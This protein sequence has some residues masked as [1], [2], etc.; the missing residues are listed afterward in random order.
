VLHK[1][2][3][4][5]RAGE[6]IGIIGP[7]GGG[8]STLV[9]VALGLL[10]VARGEVRLFGQA[11]TWGRH[12]PWLGYVGNPSRN[13]GESGLPLDLTV[14]Q[15]MRAHVELFRCSGE[16]LP[17]AAW[18]SRRLELDSA[19]VQQQSIRE[20]SD[21]WR[22]RLLVYLALAKRTQLVLADEATAGLDPAHRAELLAVVRELAEG[23]RMAVVWVTHHYDELVYLRARV[24]HMASGRLSAL[25][26][27]QWN[28]R[29]GV[30][31]D[32]ALL[33][34][35][36]AATV[37]QALADALLDSAARRIDLVVERRS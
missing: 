17:H 15:L 18:L 14:R 8:K 20:L 5:V 21:G 27:G 37:L 12:V 33:P 4:T 10:P 19:E 2:D 29:L 24:L 26:P 34:G 1:V 22:Q 3:L 30:D 11:P 31:G 6:R 35:L 25:P 28:C 23:E 13:D 32:S 7:N 9:K 16:E 36:D